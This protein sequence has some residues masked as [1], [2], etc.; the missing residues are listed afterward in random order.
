[1]IQGFSGG[2][3]RNTELFYLLDL[4]TF[5]RDFAQFK[6]LDHATGPAITFTRASDGTFFDADGVLQT[7]TTNAPRFDHD[8]VTGA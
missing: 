6:T 3:L 5:Q 7:A 1:M 8:P 4:P 2:L